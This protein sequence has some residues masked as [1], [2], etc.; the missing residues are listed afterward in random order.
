MLLVGQLGF[1]VSLAGVNTVEHGGHKCAPGAF[2]PFVGSVYNIQ[3]IF[4]R[5]GLLIEL[6]K[7]GGHREN[8]H[9]KTTS[10]PSKILRDSSAA[11]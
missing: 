5:N 9:G 8:F 3:P 11:K 1:G 7:G 10:C 4:K 6:A 2:A